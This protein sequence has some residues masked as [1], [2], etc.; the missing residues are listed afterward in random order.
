MQR[1]TK[2]GD[3]AA[4]PRP[5]QPE[6]VLRDVNVDEAILRAV[7]Q[8]EGSVGRTRLVAILR[9]SGAKALQSAGHDQLDSFGTLDHMSADDVM[10]A[11]DRLIADGTLQPAGRIRWS[12]VNDVSDLQHR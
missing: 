6:R 4:A 12:S 9:G 8:A 3:G 2:A 10:A 1:P 5:P 7:D 11:V